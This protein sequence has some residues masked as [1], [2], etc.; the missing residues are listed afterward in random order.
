MIGVTNA[1]LSEYLNRHTGECNKINKEASEGSNNLPHDIR[2]RA[3]FFMNLRR[4]PGIHGNQIGYLLYPF[5]IA[6]RDDPL[7]YIRQAKATMDRKK[8]S[9][10]ASFS[11]FLVKCLHKFRGMK[12]II[13]PLHLS[14]LA[15]ILLFLFHLASILFFRASCLRD[16]QLK[17]HCI[18]QMFLVPKKKSV[19]LAI[20]WPIL[21]Q[22]AMG[23]LLLSV[24]EGIIPDPEQ[25]CDDL[26]DSFNLIKSAV[27]AKGMVMN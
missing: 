17:Q 13:R 7:D 11:H 2:L 24:D 18:S 5:N 14:S 22:V 16:C 25:L 1:G 20:Q 12:V 4:S 27:I 8:A 15:F 21:F 26:E 10:E 9:L 6:L 3:A 19:S 23:N